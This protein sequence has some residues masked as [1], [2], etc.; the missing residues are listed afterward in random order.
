[1]LLRHSEPGLPQASHKSCD[2]ANVGVIVFTRLI[3]VTFSIPWAVPAVHRGL[4]AGGG[5]YYSC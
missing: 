3:V 4:L 5:D 2:G 1:M